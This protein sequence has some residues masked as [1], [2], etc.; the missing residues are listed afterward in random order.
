MSPIY[1]L[2]QKDAS[3]NTVYDESGKALYDWGEDRPAGASAGWNP[4]ANLEEDKYLG[5]SDNLSGRTFVEIGGLKEGALKGL[6][7][8]S[9]FGFDY[10]MNKSKTYWNPNFGNGKS[11]NGMLAVADGRTFSYTFNQILYWDRTFGNH[12]IDFMGGH[13]FYK[14]NYQYLYGEKTGFPFG[15]LYELDAATT[16][17]NASSYTNN[18]AIESYFTRLNYDFNDKYYFSASYRRDGTSRFKKE[19]RF[20]DFWSVGAS[21]RLSQENF[22]QGIVWLNNLT[23]KASYGVQGNDNIGSLYAWQAFYSLAYP[24]QS[25]PGA[26]VTSLENADLKWEKNNNFNIGLEGRNF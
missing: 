18:Y 23:V 3:G 16:V 14:Y 7:L 2:Y 21:W 25:F 22:M 6:K 26:I 9:N 24:N 20:G 15:G 13:E 11:T 19:V 12:H 1:P 5:L 8:T 17:S 10:A 4:L